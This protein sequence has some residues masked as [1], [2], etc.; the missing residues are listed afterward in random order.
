MSICEVDWHV[1]IQHRFAVSIRY[2]LHSLRIFH[3]IGWSAL[4]ATAPGIF[5]FRQIFLAFHYSL[6]STFSIGRDGYL[7]AHTAF[8]SLAG[9][10]VLLTAYASSDYFGK[11]RAF[12]SALFAGA[13]TSATMWYSI[14][15]VS[16][17]LVSFT[18]GVT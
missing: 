8:S 5:I 4:A 1:S 13:C 18:E 9:V 2:S 6:L 7:Y 12:V 16:L 15:Q 14:F 11:S 3:I 17:V 10:M